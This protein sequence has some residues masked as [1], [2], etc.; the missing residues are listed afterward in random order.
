MN[1]GL[2]LKTEGNI[3]EQGL[4]TG[5]AALGVTVAVSFLQ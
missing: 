2:C 1:S 5:E 3:H 4:P